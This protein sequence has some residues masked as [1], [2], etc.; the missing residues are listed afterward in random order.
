MSHSLRGPRTKVENAYGKTAPRRGPS[1][2]R[3]PPRNVNGPRSVNS[4]FSFSFFH[5]STTES[6]FFYGKPRRSPSGPVVTR[7]YRVFRNRRRPFV[8]PVRDSIDRDHRPSRVLDESKPIRTYTRRGNGRNVS[9]GD[10][11]KSR[12]PV[13]LG[14]RRTSDRAKNRPTRAR[15]A[16][17]STRLFDAKSTHA[18]SRLRFDVIITCTPT[19]VFI[20]T[21]QPYV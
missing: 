19:Y 12:P 7:S 6:S 4:F 3:N 1:V 15:L 2:R 20:G 10:A 21:R 14:A 13:P 9:R 18:F 16:R 11:F 8:V 17:P 5:L